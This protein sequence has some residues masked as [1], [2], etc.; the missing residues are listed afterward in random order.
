[1]PDKRLDS[2][3]RN[4]N[5]NGKESFMN[6]QKISIEDEQIA[7]PTK[8]YPNEP[9]LSPYKYLVELGFT[10]PLPDALS[11]NFNPSEKKIAELTLTVNN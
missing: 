7:K 10:F 8:Q 1:M 2:G 3:Q 4:C 11:Q 6:S 9:L 5:I